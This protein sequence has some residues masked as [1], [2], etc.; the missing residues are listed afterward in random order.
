MWYFFFKEKKLVKICAL[1]QKKKEQEQGVATEINTTKSMDKSM[2]VVYPS[3]V[4]YWD[5]RDPLHNKKWAVQLN[6]EVSEAVMV[7]V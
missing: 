7:L 2:E 1:A 5:R 4:R 3:T 6:A